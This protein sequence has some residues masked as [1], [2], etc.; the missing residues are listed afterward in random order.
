MSHL[1]TARFPPGRGLAQWSW[2]HSDLYAVSLVF[3][4][5]KPMDPILWECQSPRQ[6]SLSSTCLSLGI[7]EK[8][9]KKVSHRGTP[10]SL[11]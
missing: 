8:R 3:E 9:K 6:L 11:E 5:A 10:R 1:E 4:I 2:G 7:E